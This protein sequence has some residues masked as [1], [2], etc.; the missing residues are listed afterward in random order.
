MSLF[1]N[2]LSGN[3]QRASAFLR[4]ERG[5]F[6]TTL[7]VTVVAVA[8]CAGL[9]FDYSRISR[10]QS[11]M[12]D[13]LDA[14]I[15]AVGNRMTNGVT[16]ETQLRDEFEDF[17]FANLEMRG[18]EIRDIRVA[19]FDVDPITGKIRGKAEAD[20]DLS[21]LKLTGK[22]D[23]LIDSESEATFSTDT[24]EVAMV[25]DVTGSMKGSKIDALKLAASDAVNTL[26]PE[27]TSSSRVRIGL[28]P[29]SGAVNPGKTYAQA[30]SDGAS[31]ECVTERSGSLQH[32]DASYLDDPVEDAT[33]KKDKCPSNK[34][35]LLTK[36]RDLLIADIAAYET[37]GYTAG[38]IGIAWAYYMLSENWNSLWPTESKAASYDDDV[39]KVAI[40]MTDGEFNT[41]YAGVPYNKRNKQADKSN[42]AAVALCDHMKADKGSAKGIIVYSVAFKAPKSA[43][44]TLKKCANPDKSGR[45]YYYDASNEDQLRAAFR[46][47]A[48]DIGN[49]RLS[50]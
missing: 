35:R 50:K 46:A 44:E 27:A 3:F 14:A 30:A 6:A 25:L 23:Q 49:L 1:P 5:T 21:F 29:Y 12:D 47:I 2:R 38:H 41:Y 17:L 45:T 15:L 31:E 33:T 8:L 20:L 37:D 18:L 22:T 7:G 39:T 19:D 40:I 32:T 11:A 24:I 48:L 16:S 4:D 43:K 10:A 36:D 42:A 9:A 34:V 13:S 26:I 28:V